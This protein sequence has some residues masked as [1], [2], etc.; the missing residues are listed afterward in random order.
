MQP[1]FQDSLGKPAPERLNQIGFWWRDDGVALASAGQYAIHLQSAQVWHM[2]RRDHTVLPSTHT[3]IHKWNEPY[4]PLLQSVTALWHWLISRPAEG[5][6]LSWPGWLCEI[7]RWFA[8]PKMVAHPSI[9]HGGRES[10]LQP[11]SDEFSA[12]TTRLPSPI[13]HCTSLQTDNYASASSLYLFT[14][15]GW[16]LF[17]A[18]NQQCQSTECSWKDVKL[19]F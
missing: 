11:L 13:D 1:F 7:L 17:L 3:F 2:L 9:S 5:R 6:R 16:M 19:N 18:P 15:W 10:N 8:R 14:G 4:L 12:V